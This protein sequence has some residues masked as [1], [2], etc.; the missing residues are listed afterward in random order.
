VV[1]VLQLSLFQFDSEGSPEILQKAV[2]S[3]ADG[4]SGI[5]KS[6]KTITAH[7]TGVWLQCSR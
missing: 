2:D 6:V 1:M 7:N 3:W 5:C 4:L